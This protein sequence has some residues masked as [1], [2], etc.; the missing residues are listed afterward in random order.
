M[1]K[2][3]WEYLDMSYDNIYFPFGIHKVFLNRIKLAYSLTF[4]LNGTP[5]FSVQV[6]VV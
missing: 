4:S 6:I 3:I 5:L 1:Q 2:T